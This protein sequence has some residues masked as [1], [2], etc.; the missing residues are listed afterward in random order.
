MTLG[1]LINRRPR[2]RASDWARN[3]AIGQE[4]G[5][6]MKKG[7]LEKASQ[8]HSLPRVFRDP[9]EISRASRSSAPCN[10]RRGSRVLFA[11]ATP[12]V[13]PPPKAVSLAGAFGLL[14][15]FPGAPY[16]ADRSRRSNSGS[17]AMSRPSVG[18]SWPIRRRH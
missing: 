13:P 12:P 3:P 16:S 14:R 1:D 17:R 2:Q 11:S 10:H 18:P 9:A 8:V 6:S 5:R 15:S 4:M 7:R